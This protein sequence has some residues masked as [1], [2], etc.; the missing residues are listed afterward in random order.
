LI[1]S[2]ASRSF[3]SIPTPASNRSTV[4]AGSIPFSQF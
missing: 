2:I 4:T 1:E 3:A